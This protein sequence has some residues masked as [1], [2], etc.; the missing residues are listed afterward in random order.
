MVEEEKPEIRAA[1]KLMAELLRSKP[2]K[3]EKEK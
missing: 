3:K 2:K 1:Y